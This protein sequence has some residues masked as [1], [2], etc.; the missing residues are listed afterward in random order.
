MLDHDSR[1]WFLS[2]GGLTRENGQHFRDTVLSRGATQDY[3][4]MFEAFAGHDPSP[5]PL[6][7]DRGLLDTP[8]K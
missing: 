8:K 4:K 6:L 2:H 3:Y 1:H 5:K 7:E